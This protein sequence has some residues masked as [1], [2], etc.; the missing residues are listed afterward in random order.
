M[1]K[2][3]RKK[4]SIKKTLRIVIPFL[5]LLVLIINIKRIVT[6]TR[7]KITGYEYETIEAFNELDIYNDIKKHDYSKTLEVASKSDVFKKEYLNN[8]L[9]ISYQEDD[10]KFINNINVL[11]AL[12][13]NSNDVN[14]MY[15]VLSLDSIELIMNNVYY[16][17][18]YNILGLNYFHEVK[19]EKYLSYAS[20]NELDYTDV[21]TYVNIGLDHDY[22]TDMVK[23]EKEDDPLVLV[24]KYNILSSNYIPSDL[25]AIT[26]KY[27][28]GYNNKLRHEARIAFEKMCDAALNDNI[29]IYSGSAY[30]S[31]SYQQNLYNRYVNQD[32]K[33]KADTYS[34]RAGSSEHQTGL[35]TDIL[36]AKID[37]ISASDK[38]YT[39]LINNSYKYGY[40]LRYPKG[41]EKITGY[42]Y[43]EWHFRYLGIELA[44]DVYDSKLT[45]DEYV[46]RNN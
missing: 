28:K 9:D 16:N 23:I 12:G 8:Y 13:Y 46:A 30:R 27:N 34:A 6:F 2:K 43:E 32:G 7:S 41:K 25:E 15:E 39:W 5:I 38:E 4:F 40:I 42:M 22:Y 18:L 26:S 17:D 14:K 44:K 36:N 11:L 35:A 45:Y 1:V 21:V 10:K 20:Q 19:L 33:K 3:K 37:Y 31:Y 29:K 24:N